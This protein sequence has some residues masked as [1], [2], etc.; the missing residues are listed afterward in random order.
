MEEEEMMRGV[1]GDASVTVTYSQVGVFP[2]KKK[3]KEVL[4]WMAWQSIFYK[5]EDCKSLI[6]H[7]MHAADKR[8]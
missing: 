6:L 2:C 3:K 8:N 4:S 7:V 1:R 5:K